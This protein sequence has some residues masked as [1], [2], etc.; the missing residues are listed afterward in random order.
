MSEGRKITLLQLNDSHGY[1][2]AHP[3]LFWEGDREVFRCAGGFARISS[4][5]SQIRDECRGAVIARARDSQQSVTS[6]ALPMRLS[7][8][9]KGL[10]KIDPLNYL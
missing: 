5:F 3:E 2:K 8:F 9:S 6:T 10:K 7:S 4:L 1:L